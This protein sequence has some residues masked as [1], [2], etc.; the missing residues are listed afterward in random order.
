M[1][2][3]QRRYSGIA[4]AVPRYR[5]LSQADCYQLSDLIHQVMVAISG[6][7]PLQQAELGIMTATPLALAK[8][9]T[10]LENRPAAR[11]EQSLHRK[12]RRGFPAA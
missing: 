8:R 1:P 10:D 7:I 6:T 5:S 9:M 4:I 12:F 3:Q 2:L 11:G